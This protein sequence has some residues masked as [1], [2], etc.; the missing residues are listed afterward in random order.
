MSKPDAEPCLHCAL[1]DAAVAFKNEGNHV[2]VR[3]LISAA[4]NL[5][6]EAVA[7]AP[8]AEQRIALQDYA[9]DQFCEHTTQAMERAEGEPVGHA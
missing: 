6:S 5:V 1:Y 7:A 8:T 9:I 3:T 2:C 4:M